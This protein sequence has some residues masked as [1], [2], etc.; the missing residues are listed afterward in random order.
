MPYYFRTFFLVACLFIGS[1]L[2]A[3]CQSQAQRDESTEQTSQTQS[4]K[5]HSRHHRKRPS[6]S[7]QTNTAQSQV[8]NGP[9]PQKVYDVLAYV[10]ANSRAMAGYVG[11]RRFGNFEN[12]LPRSDTD[13]RPID[14]QEWDVNPK[15]GGRNRGTERLVT[16][17]DGRAWY[18]NDHYNTF[19][20]V[21]VN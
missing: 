17:S 9:I 18:T 1:S 6:E 21:H 3:D 15:V 19:V 16:G 14:Y 2:L 13:G 4:R 5:K 12:H 11:G 10:K 7:Y 20:E 8:K